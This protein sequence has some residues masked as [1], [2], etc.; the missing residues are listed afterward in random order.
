MS[1]GSTYPY[2]RSIWMNSIEAKRPS[3]R[4]RENAAPYLCPVKLMLK[5]NR[6]FWLVHYSFIDK[7][8]I[9]R[10][11]NDFLVSGICDFGR[12]YGL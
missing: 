2:K 7:Y 4:E 12:C 5:L 10:G 3:G 11:T 8:C 6:I 1:S 9:I